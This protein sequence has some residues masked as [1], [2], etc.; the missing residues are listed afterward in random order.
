[1]VC[2]VVTGLFWCWP[3]C[4]CLFCMDRPLRLVP[5]VALMESG[6]CCLDC[7]KSPPQGPFAAL[8]DKQGPQLSSPDF[9]HRNTVDSDVDQCA[10]TGGQPLKHHLRLNTQTHTNTQSWQLC[11]WGLSELVPSSLRFVLEAVYCTSEAQPVNDRQ[12]G[13]SVCFRRASN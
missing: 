1:M 11:P 8:N 3:R 10:Q 6:M 5:A 9:R 13:L 7:V 4:P 12:L 2:S